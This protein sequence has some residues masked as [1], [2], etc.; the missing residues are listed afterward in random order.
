MD[1]FLSLH[2]KAGNNIAYP[3]EGEVVICRKLSEIYGLK[4]GD[5]ITLR[6]EDGTVLQ[7]CISGVCENYIYSYIYL[8]ADTYAKQAGVIPEF[9]SVFINLKEDADAHMAS[10]ALMGLEDISSVTVNADMMD[11]LNSMM[12]SID[13]IVLVIVLCAAALAFIVLYNLTNINITERIREIA[14]IKVLGF[15]RGETAAYVFRE[16]TILSLIGAGAGLVLGYFMHQF[17][18]SKVVVDMV[19]FDVYIKP[20]SYIYSFLLTLIFAW[21][22]NRIMTFKLE[23]VNMA[24]SLKS[25]D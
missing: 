4:T 11:R 22:I 6:E 15:H 23:R 16:N 13:Y 3:G 9:T 5:M 18:M 2:D 7:V 14:T 10:A 20:V 17:V 1:G 24:E 21:L 25:V 19:S 12:G 8:H